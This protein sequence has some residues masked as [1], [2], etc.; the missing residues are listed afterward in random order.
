MALTNALL[1]GGAA[2]AKFLWRGKEIC[3]IQQKE[4]TSSQPHILRIIL[5]CLLSRL[6]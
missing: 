6:A 5:F 2:A 3:W 4:K 1:F